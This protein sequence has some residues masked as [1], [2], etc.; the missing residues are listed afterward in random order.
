[1]NRAIAITA[2][3][4]ALLV[5]GYQVWVAFQL[6]HVASTYSDD[7]D[8][9]VRGDTHYTKA[10]HDFVVWLH[11]EA[12][13]SGS[14]AIALLIGAV[15][16]L[17]RKAAGRWL[18]VLASVVVVAHTSVGWVVAT[19]MSHWFVEIGADDYGTLWFK[20]PSRLAIV[21]LSFLAPVVAVILALHPATRRWCRSDPAQA[22]P[23]ALRRSA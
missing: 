19:K 22:I 15:L 1:M 21:V 18:T 9:L 3:I 23:S 13:L 14:S 11:A 10:F 12:A 16:L 20:I 4:I 7:L 6:S 8:F 2:A 17:V 5:G